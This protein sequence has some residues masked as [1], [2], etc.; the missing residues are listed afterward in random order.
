[1][2]FGPTGPAVG[3]SWES[4]RSLKS[5]SIPSVPL[6]AVPLPAITGGPID[7]QLENNMPSGNPSRLLKLADRELQQL[8]EQGPEP[9]PSR[10]F[11]L[12]KMNAARFD[13]S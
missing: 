4:A 1:M 7:A 6:P 13:Q 11:K 3:T 10:K 9:Q 8:T 5:L 12:V 2:R